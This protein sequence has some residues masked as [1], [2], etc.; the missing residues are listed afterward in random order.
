MGP[1]WSDGPLWSD[2]LPLFSLLFKSP[3]VLCSLFSLR[4]FAWI[5]GVMGRSVGFWFGAWIEAVVSVDRRVDRSVGL[6]VRGSECGSDCSWVI[7]R[8]VPLL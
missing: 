7:L 5:E 8:R 6:I 2:G 3:S 1:M 4:G